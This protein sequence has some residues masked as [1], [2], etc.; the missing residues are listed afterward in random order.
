MI[1]ALA[2]TMRRGCSWVWLSLVLAGLVVW[3]AYA[4]AQDAKARSAA[5]KGAPAPKKEAAKE[6]DDDEGD[7]P[8]AAAAA[9]APSVNP[10][11]TFETFKDERAEKALEVFKS[12]PG[13]RDCPPQVVSQVRAM[14]AAAAAADRDEIQRFVDG[15]AYR[16][17]DKSNINGLIAPPPNTK[18]GVDPSRAIKDASIN[19]IDSLNAAKQVRNAGF[20]QV[21]NQVLIATLP[22]LLDNNLVPRVQAMIVLGETGDPAA[23]PVFIN[24]LKDPNQ[25]VWVKLWAARGIS[26]VADNGAR[27][28]QALSVQQASAA[29]KALADF[30]DAEKDAPW[31]A[32]VRAL[33]GIGA[34]RQASVPVNMNKVEMAA[35]ALRLLA[36][37]EAKPE[38]RAAAA[39]ALGMV[40]VNPAVSGYNF[41]LVA[42]HIGRFA[43]EIGAQAA[44]SFPKPKAKPKAAAKAAEKAA[45][46][47]A[48][49]DEA[50]HEEPAAPEPAGNQTLSEYLSGLLVAPVFQAF[51]GVD[52]VRESGL[53]KQP[54]LGQAATIVKQVADLQSALARASVEMVRGT[55]G[56]FEAHVQDLKDRVAALNALLAKSPPKDFHLVPGNGPEYRPAAG[57][58]ADANAAPAKAV[59]APGGR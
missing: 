15:M 29:A 45:A 6:K 8:A 12:V 51:N 28:D 52:G 44:Q 46:K 18:P 17:T 36:D 3:P 30:L 2:P 25:T 54:N 48:A 26:N 22:K 34:M 7:A 47:P 32:Q 43:A 53:L 16:L 23:I 59:G 50:A 4:R 10:G 57:E 21:Y 58:V 55:P 35:V 31:P 14:A 49:K 9:E 19:L 11:G 40:R 5:A 56:Q 38:V 1:Q 39:W 24:Q 27:V 13:L 33:E 42:H 37:P 20:L 41:N